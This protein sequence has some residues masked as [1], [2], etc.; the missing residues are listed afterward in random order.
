MVL[1]RVI[2]ILF[3]SGAAPLA[4]LSARAASGHEAVDAIV[5]NTIDS[6]ATDTKAET[7]VFFA[8]DGTLRLMQQDKR[9]TGTWA[10]TAGKLCLKETPGAPADCYAV[11]VDGEDAT[12]T[13]AKLIVRGR[14]LSGNPMRLGSPREGRSSF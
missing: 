2:L 7:F 8:K 3:L 13:S 11:D 5:G 14:I 10:R 4:A 9:S 6:R 12:F 1:P